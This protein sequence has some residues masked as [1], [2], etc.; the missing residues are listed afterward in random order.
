M[1]AKGSTNEMNRAQAVEF[2]SELYFGEHHIP[3][4]GYCGQHG[5]REFGPGSWYVNHYGDIATYDYSFLTRLVFLAHDRCVR[6]SVQNGGPR[7]IKI[8]I[9]QRDKREGSM[10][11]RHPT[12]AAALDEW[13]ERHPEP[14]P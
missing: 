5:V 3:A 7:R 12:I 6:A 4:R 1:S 10:Y 9:W 14:Q 11:E 8:V 13:R 2:F